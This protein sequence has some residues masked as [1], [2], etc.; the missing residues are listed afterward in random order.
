MLP[1]EPCNSAQQNNYYFQFLVNW[2]FHK[3]LQAVLVHQKTLWINGADF[4]QAKCPSFYLINI[5]IVLTHDK[6]NCLQNLPEQF[7]NLCVKV[8]WWI[9]NGK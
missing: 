4:L 6:S 7:E 1:Q 3:V 5:V 9:K 2:L 8:N